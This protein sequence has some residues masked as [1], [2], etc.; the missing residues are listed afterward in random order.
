M[1]AR[2][3][4]TDFVPGTRYEYSNGGYLLLSEVVA[5]A[6]GMAFARYV[7]RAILAPLR[8]TRSFVLD[9][10]R[11]TDADVA[12]GYVPQGG[13][14]ALRDSYPLY[15]GAG[16]VMTT[17]NDIGRYHRDVTV[18][19]KVWT[20]AVAAI[21]EAPGRLTDGQP[22]AMT[23]VDAVYGGGLMLHGRWIEH[24]GDAE[25]FK[26]EYARLRDRPF[27]IAVFCNR[28][29]VVP[30]DKA[31]AMLR[32][33]AGDIPVLRSPATPPAW[34]NGRFA[35]A[36][37]PA[38]YILSTTDGRMIITRMPD[39]PGI[40]ASAPIT[41]KRAI[42]GTFVSDDGRMR[43]VESGDGFMIDNWRASGMRFH[44]LAD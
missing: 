36:D 31:D 22:V 11:P 35:S 37:L 13:H 41:L 21:L 38:R 34:A 14:Y 39:R 33:V 9:G 24:G 40:A 6:S 12:R 5:R 25:G 29:D 42:D 15:G 17:I 27:G 23:E 7:D 32:V 44:R 3:S 16:G 26:A 18:D 43:I 20:P 8:M 28:G 30:V 1:V 2:Q 19:R 10:A 4:D